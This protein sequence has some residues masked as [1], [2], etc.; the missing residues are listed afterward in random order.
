MTKLRAGLIGDHISQSRLA[1]GLK[2]MCDDHGLTLN[3][4]R[5]DSA[6][7]GGFDF[8]RTVNHCRTQGWNGVTV[9]HPYKAAAAQF[10]GKAA[11]ES[12]QQLG[13]SN[14]L[15][16][17]PSFSAHNTDFTGFVAAWGAI[18]KDRA[19]GRVAM[20][21]AGG[22]ARALGPALK[23]LGATEIAIWDLDENAAAS[24]AQRIGAPARA[25][26]LS[27]AGEIAAQASGLVNATPLGMTYHPGSAFDPDWISDQSWAFDAVYTPTDTEFLIDAATKN[28][29][30]L[31]GF[32]LFRF[33]AMKSFEA[34]TG[35][36]PDPDATLPKLNALRPKKDAT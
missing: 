32:D 18:F 20:A 17:R 9:T 4:E 10:A 11:S 16:F 1:A 36:S 33:M 5:I 7:D 12:V 2:I 27:D 23:H 22:V 3:F 24:L 19:P 25:V 31:S 34:Y 21:G 8:E 29:E 6:K 15:I 26:A 28:L 35:L 14:T 30:I 13:A